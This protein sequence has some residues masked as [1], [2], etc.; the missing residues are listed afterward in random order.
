MPKGQ[1]SI[2]PCIARGGVTFLQQPETPVISSEAR[3][4]VIIF[5]YG[6]LGMRN[7]KKRQLEMHPIKKST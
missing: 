5:F 4:P 2:A 7:I 3:N 6:G 1:K